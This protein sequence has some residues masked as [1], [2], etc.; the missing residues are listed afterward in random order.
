MLYLGIDH[1]EFGA[2]AAIN[3]KSEIVLLVDMPKKHKDLI[4]IFEQLKGEEVVSVIEKVLTIYTYD[5]VAKRRVLRQ[6]GKSLV[7]QATGVGYTLALVDVFSFDIRQIRASEWQKDMN[8]YG[9]SGKT[10]HIQAAQA[11]FPDAELKVKRK[12]MDGRADAL[13]MAEW[14]RGKYGKEKV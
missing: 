3:D 6:S 11:L 14:L 13:L 9:K 7:T 1:G 12:M 10:P 8:V 2:L 5:P 4:P